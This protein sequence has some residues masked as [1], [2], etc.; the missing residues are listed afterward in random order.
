MKFIILIV[1]VL[2]FFSMLKSNFNN[3]LVIYGSSTLSL[4]RDDLKNLA[5]GS[6]LNFVN[7]SIGGQ[8]LETVEGLVESKPIYIK[9]SKNIEKDKTLV[10]IIQK[11]GGTL[12]PRSRFNV[13]LSDGTDGVIDFDKSIFLSDI[14]PMENA[15]L[16]VDF[17]FSS[18]SE[19][20]IYIINI[21]KNNITK[22]YQV[23]DV[24]NSI[25]GI[26]GKLDE[27]N[28]NKYIVIGYFVDSRSKTKKEILLINSEL[29][30]I[31]KEKYF[32]I[33]EYLMSELIWSDLRVEP[34]KI[35][36]NSQENK[37]LAPSLR[38]DEKHLNDKV[39]KLIVK[40]LKN[41]VSELNYL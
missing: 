13:T 40:R 30:R 24:L 28:R 7:H 36:L 12:R 4:L 8:T 15:N 33:Q 22:G 41:K 2:F 16:R 25:Q 38:R 20:D 32:D 11:G 21:G 1:S 29:K 18:Y 39:G 31:Y 9:T 14:K 10:D 35:D 26:T 37:E 3:Q 27:Y 34:T 23:V 6:R 19:N 17:G 5:H